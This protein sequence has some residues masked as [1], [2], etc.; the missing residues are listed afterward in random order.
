MELDPEV[1]SY[2]HKVGHRWIDMVLASTALL[3][4]ITSIIIAIQNE[5]NMRR[6]VT[7]NSWPY[8]ALNQGNEK[9]GETIV[10]FDVRNAGIG[11]ATLEKLVVTYDGKA[12]ATTVE[13][14]KRCCASAG[15][16]DAIHRVSIDVVQGRVFTPREETSFFS[17]RKSDTDGAMWEKLNIERFKVGMSVCYSSVFGE[18]WITSFGRPKPDSVKSCDAL[19]GPAYDLHLN[20]QGS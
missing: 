13:L 9:N 14:I 15:G 4:S 17:V 19:T 6:L 5:S 12:V 3:I 16:L 11:P 18:H 10:H 2:P 7:A 8:I 20:A 1:H